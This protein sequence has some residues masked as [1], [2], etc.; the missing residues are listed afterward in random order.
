MALRLLCEYGSTKRAAYVTE[1]N[2]RLIEHHL[3]NARKAMG[4]FGVDVRLFL[5]WDRW[6]RTNQPVKQE[7]K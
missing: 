4:M 2:S 7:N 6:V 3:R 5:N 1:I